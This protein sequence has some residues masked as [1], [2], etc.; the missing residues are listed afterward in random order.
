[1]ITVAG[2]IMAVTV[3]AGAAAMVA[4]LQAGRADAQAFR[5]DRLI[6]IVKTVKPCLRK[7]PHYN[8]LLFALTYVQL[9]FRRGNPSPWP[10]SS[11]A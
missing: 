1:M 4:A 10:G 6:T 5:F 2:M 3:V 11:A 7:S 8:H 9:E